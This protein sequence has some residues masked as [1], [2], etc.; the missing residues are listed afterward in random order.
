[1]EHSYIV[2][3]AIYGDFEEEKE[4]SSL[5][6][7]NAMRFFKKGQEKSPGKTW[8]ESGWALEVKPT[9]G[10]EWQSLEEGLDCL[11]VSL[12]P[13]KASIRQLADEYDVSIYCGHFFSTFGG[14][15]H[16]QPTY[17]RSLQISG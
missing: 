9:I 16:F 11:L 4:I 14:G 6:G 13:S 3:L 17:L 15:R 2:E 5:V 12:L 1:M 10:K 8:E 7:F